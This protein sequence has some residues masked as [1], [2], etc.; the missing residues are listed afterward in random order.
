MINKL[1]SYNVNVIKFSS[2]LEQFSECKSDL[3]ILRDSCYRDYFTPMKLFL[4]K[5]NYY[6]DQYPI[7]EEQEDKLGDMKLLFQNDYYK[8][9]L[10]NINE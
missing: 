7:T 1:K 5:L 4:E 6:M 2:I 10:I 9:C 3:N 8:N